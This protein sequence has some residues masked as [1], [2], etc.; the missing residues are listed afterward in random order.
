VLFASPSPSCSPDD[1]YT[2]YVL[3]AVAGNANN[4]ILMQASTSCMAMMLTPVAS[5]SQTTQ[6]YIRE[7]VVYGG[8]LTLSNGE[9]AESTRITLSGVPIALPSVW[10]EPLPSYDQSLMPIANHTQSTPNILPI[11]RYPF[12]AYDI[13]TNATTPRMFYTA[14]Q[15]GST[16]TA[17]NGDTY[18]SVDG[19]TSSAG[20][21]HFDRQPIVNTGAPF[22]VRRAGGM[23]HL[24]NGNLVMFGGKTVVNGDANVYEDLV[25][26]SPNYGKSWWQATHDAAW[27]D[28]SD[29]A[30]CAIPGTNRILMCGGQVPSGG[31]SECWTSTDG[32]GREW[33]MQSTG[34]FSGFSGGTC[35]ALYDS[36]LFG[37][38]NVNH[39]LLLIAPTGPVYQSHD[40]GVTFTRIATI[41]FATTSARNFLNAVAD[42]MDDVYVFGGQ[43]TTDSNVYYR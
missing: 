43:G 12:C 4:F 28:R 17:Q 38:M 19:W 2:W 23:V 11:R 22:V 37:G 41:P 5:S 27:S 9:P 3:S 14:G 20:V 1:G 29:M 31:D 8:Q 40:F 24:A 7:L 6:Y 16:T 30:Y 36:T 39:T 25:Y 10:P 13:H 34:Q 15:N 18:V 32:I 33:T 35:V 21:I 42:R 26:Y